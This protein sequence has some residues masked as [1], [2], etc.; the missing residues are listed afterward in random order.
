MTL[1]REPRRSAYARGYTKAWDRASKA[2]R[3][4]Y[5]LCGMR[6][7][8]QVPVMSRCDQQARHT[9][10]TLTDHVIPHRG[11]RTLFWDE[12]GNWQSMC[13]PCHDRKTHAEDLADAETRA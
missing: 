3:L 6:P 13:K 11:D 10:A 12:H 2:F 4:R 8:D 5:P 9:P 7:E 1:P